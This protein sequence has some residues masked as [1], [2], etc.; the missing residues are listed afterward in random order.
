MDVL[1]MSAMVLISVIHIRV[2]FFLFRLHP[3]SGEA[4]LSRSLTFQMQVMCCVD[5]SLSH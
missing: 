3:I 4:Y 5:R 1:T 2:F